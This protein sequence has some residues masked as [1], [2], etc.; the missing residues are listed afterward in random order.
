MK[1]NTIRMIACIF[2]FIFLLIAC[3]P[4]ISTPTDLIPTN[5][6]TPV[7]TENLQNTVIPQEP[8]I[9]TTEVYPPVDNQPDKSGFPSESPYPAPITSQ[10]LADLPEED[11][12]VLL[13][14]LPIS[15]PQRLIWNPAG[16]EFALLGYDSLTYYAY[17][18]L[19]KMFEYKS[20]DDKSIL[21]V[22]NDGL[23]FAILSNNNIVQVNNWKTGEQVTFLVDFGFVSAKFS[24]DSKQLIFTLMEERAAK[25]V[26]VQDGNIEKEL[27]GFDTAAPVYEVRFAADG[28]HLLWFA[29]ATLQISDIESN[30]MGQSFNHEDFIASFTSNPQN[31]LIVTSAGAMEND[32]FKPF[33]FFWDP[34]SGEM[35]NKIEVTQPAYSMAFSPDGSVLA[36]SQEGNIYLID[37][38]T[39]SITRGF[40]AHQ[41]GISQ[42][43]FSD[44][45]KIISSTGSDLIIKFW[46]M[47]E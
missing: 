14:S 20:S 27:S 33:I 47:P 40:T 15:E 44:D 6:D 32:Q 7:P 41:E 38:A 1:F 21:D 23:H 4:S 9:K 35:I 25:L 42:L 18:S 28:K 43:V 3:S 46:E 34:Q 13:Q 5:V 39:Q 26:N 31:T 12:L 11:T 37:A 17:P 45:G 10:N 36:V 30:T 19:D 24:P 8:P 29:R 16:T 2:C 22:A